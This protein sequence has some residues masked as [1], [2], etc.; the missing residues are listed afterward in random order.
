VGA[1]SRTCQTTPDERDHDVHVRQLT[2][3]L[4]YHDGFHAVQEPSPRTYEYE[5]SFYKVRNGRHQGEIMDG[6]GYVCAYAAGG[7][8]LGD[9]ESQRDGVTAVG[10]RC[11]RLSLCGFR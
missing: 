2:P 7:A 11:D 3:D 5:S 10:L 6:Q 9:M 4:Q 8:E 1:R